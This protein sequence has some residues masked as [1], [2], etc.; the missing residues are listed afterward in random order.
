MLGYNCSHLFEASA[1]RVADDGNLSA[2]TRVC[3]AFCRL[4]PAF[5]MAAFRTID[6]HK[7]MAKVSSAMLKI[8]R[9]IQVADALSWV[10]DLF[11]I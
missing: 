7:P 10:I 6:I 8:A 5:F 9:S 3:A 4:R 11:F 2:R 1:T